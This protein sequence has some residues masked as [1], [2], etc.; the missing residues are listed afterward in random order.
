MTQPS[1][2]YAAIAW[3]DSVKK[4]TPK[5][6]EWKR[7]PLDTQ[8]SYDGGWWREQKFYVYFPRDPK[9]KVRTAWTTAD[10]EYRANLLEI[11]NELGAEGWEVVTDTVTASAVGPRL[12]WDEAGFPIDWRVLLKRRVAG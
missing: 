10:T 11:L 1:W 2:E 7:L 3:N 5:D 12:G 6:P 9:P 8:A 4:I